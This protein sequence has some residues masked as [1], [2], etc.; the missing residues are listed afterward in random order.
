MKVGESLRTMEPTDSPSC[1]FIRLWSR[2][3]VSRFE[4]RCTPSNRLSARAGF[5]SAILSGFGFVVFLHRESY[6]Y[7]FRRTISRLGCSR[8]I[9]ATVAYHALSVAVGRA[10]AAQFAT[11]VPVAFESQ[12]AGALY[13]RLPRAQGHT[14]AGEGHLGIAG[15]DHATLLCPVCG[16]GVVARFALR[17]AGRGPVVAYSFVQDPQINNRCQYLNPMERKTF[18]QLSSPEVCE[19]INR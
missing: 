7:L 6:L 3:G 15:V 18:P 5:L 4:E 13:Q 19:S 8:Y 17:A 11:A 2:R 1:L 10:V 14:A 12:A 9:P 16:P